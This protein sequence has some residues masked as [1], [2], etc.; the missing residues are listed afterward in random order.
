M[1]KGNTEPFGGISNN[2]NDRVCWTAMDAEKLA[3]R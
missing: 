2:Q 1:S 3:W